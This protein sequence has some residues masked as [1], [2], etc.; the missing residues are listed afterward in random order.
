MK[1][2]RSSK[3]KEKIRE[4]HEFLKQVK[5]DQLVDNFPVFIRRQELVR[6]L[7]RYKLFEKILGIKG[8]IIE[9]G[10]FQGASLMFFAQLSAIYEPYAFNREIIG[11]DTFKGFVDVNDKDNRACQVGNFSDSCLKVLEKSIAFY[12]SNRPVG[13]IPKIKLVKGDAVDTLPEYFKDNPHTMVAMLYLDFDLYQPTK[14]A[15]KNVLTRMPKGAVIVFDEL[16]HRVCQGE[17]LALLE[18]MNLNN[19]EIKKFPEEPLISYAV[20]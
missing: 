13:H 15:I 5:P 6:Y 20:I 17:T 14:V 16:N 3:E 1:N 11:F 18:N 2:L 8:S 4:W 9:C 12:D 19:L 10:I 7:I